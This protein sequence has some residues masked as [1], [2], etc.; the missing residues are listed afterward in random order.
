MQLFFIRLRRNWVSHHLLGLNFREQKWEDQAGP[1]GTAVRIN[2]TCITVVR[3]LAQGHY[4]D[5][6]LLLLCIAL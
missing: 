5:R 6:I 1:K 3:L 2:D 4:R